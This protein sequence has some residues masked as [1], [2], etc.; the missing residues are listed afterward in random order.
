LYVIAIKEEIQNT[1][2]QPWKGVQGLKRKMKMLD[3]GKIYPE[4]YVIS[5]VLDLHFLFWNPL[6]DYSESC[7]GYLFEFIII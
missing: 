5:P 4:K 7:E 2:I 3:T 1:Q 6:P